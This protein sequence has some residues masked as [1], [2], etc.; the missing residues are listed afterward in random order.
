MFFSSLLA[1]LVIYNSSDD[2]EILTVNLILLLLGKEIQIQ[3][4]GLTRSFA[5]RVCLV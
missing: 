3:R 5:F 2:N 1:L 4:S